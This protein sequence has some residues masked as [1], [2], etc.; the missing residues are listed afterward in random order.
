[1][2]LPHPLVCPLDSRRAVQ[3]ECP[4]RHQANL[5][6]NHQETQQAIRLAYQALSQLG[7]HL[8]SQHSRLERRPLFRLTCLLSNRRHN[9]QHGRLSRH[10]ES[11]LLNHLSVQ[12]ESLVVSLVG[13]LQTSHLMSPQLV[14]LLSRQG[15]PLANQRASLL[16]HLLLCLVSNLRV[17]RQ[18]NHLESRL[19]SHLVRRPESLHLCQA[20]LLL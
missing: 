18:D 6:S 17:S 19:W 5:Q 16:S 10:P 12:Q 2:D 20:A 15:G 11:L 14:P 4:R 9:P 7:N 1:M 8:R 13:S 3:V